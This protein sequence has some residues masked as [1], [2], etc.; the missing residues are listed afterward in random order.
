MKRFAGMMVLLLL[1]LSGMA[2]V[3]GYRVQGTKFL[4]AFDNFVWK[5]DTLQHDSIVYVDLHTDSLRVRYIDGSWSNWFYS[6]TTSGVYVLPT[7]SATVKGGIK[8][9]SGLSIDA[10]TGVLSSTGSMVYP[11]VGLAKST[12]SGWATSITDNSSNWNTAYSWGNHA[13]AGYLTSYTETD[14]TI[15]A[16]AKAPT[17][18]TYTYSEV[19]AQEPLI[20]GTNIKTINGNSILGSGNLSISG[21]TTNLGYTSSATNGIV[22]SDTGTDATIPAGSTTNAS[23]M[24]PSDKTKLNGIASGAD[25]YG[26]WA[27]QVNGGSPTTVPSANVLNFIAGTNTT[28]TPSGLSLTISS[29]GGTTTNAVTFNNSGSGAAS[30][31]TFDG[32][33]ARTISY[34]TLGAAALAGNIS[35]SF[36]ASQFNCPSNVILSGQG[37]SLDATRRISTGG[38]STIY[39]GNFDG[40]FNMTFDA[41]NGTFYAPIITGGNS[42]NW[43]TAYANI[44]KVALATSP[45]TYRNLNGSYFSDNGSNIILTMDG[46]PTN[47]SVIPVTSDGIYDALQLKADLSGASFTGAIS[48]TSTMTATDFILSSDRRLKTRIRPLNNTAWVRNIPLVSYQFKSD[49]TETTRYGVIAQDVESVNKNLVH[50]DEKGN[51]SVSYIDLLIAKIADLEKRVADLE[52]QVKAKK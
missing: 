29:T 45:S 9:G 33:V 43:N 24:L 32:S 16:W 42:S 27:F 8:V 7:A 3:K 12:G 11:G 41:S 44:G 36:S 38:S 18:P 50:K 39:F 22:T 6:G 5:G 23:L 30:G 49:S 37:L 28:I 15:Y 34:N 46:T 35:Q 4:E 40:S 2:Q 20:S 21:G 13:T 52:T 17:K 10:G 51:L 31:T 1:A 25:N 26:Y 48:S 19:G 14:P 47:N